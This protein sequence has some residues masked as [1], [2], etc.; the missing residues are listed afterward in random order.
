MNKTP[1]KS[2]QGL[3]YQ[4]IEYIKYARDMTYEEQDYNYLRNLFFHI[5]E[6]NGG[7]IDFC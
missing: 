4:F 3:P 6:N 1:E 7:K 2:C 5:L